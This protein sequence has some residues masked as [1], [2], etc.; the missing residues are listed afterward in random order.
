MFVCISHCLLYFFKCF[1]SKNT[2]VCFFFFSFQ[3]CLSHQGLQ[4]THDSLRRTQT[5][6]VQFC[7]THWLRLKTHHICHPN[8]LNEH[9]RVLKWNLQQQKQ[10]RRSFWL[11]ASNAKMNYSQ[12]N[13]PQNAWWRRWQWDRRRALAPSVLQVHVAYCIW[14]VN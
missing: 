4:F 6:S 13:R 10:P 3:T 12:R 1:P 2:P 5:G 7:A 14:T 9:F 11:F 8:M